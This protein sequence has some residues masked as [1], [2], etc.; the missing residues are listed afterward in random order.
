MH[1]CLL[2]PVWLGPVRA[3]NRVFSPPH[4]T[5]LG[6][7]GTVSEALIAYHRE[8]AKGGVGLI[9][10]E[11]MT[12]HPSYSFEESFLYAGSDQIIAGLEKLATACHPYGAPMFGQLF[13]AGR[14]VRLSRDGSRPVTYSAS[15]V[16][17][18]RYRVV[19]CPMP[20][21]MV[22]EVIESYAQAASR[23]IEGGLDGVEILASMGYLIAQF[24]NPNTNQ[25]EDEFGGDLAN[26]MRMLQEILVRCRERI[27]NDKTL[28][29]RITLNENTNS[30]MAREEMLEACRIIDQGSLVDYFSVIAGSSASMRGWVHVFPP[31]AVPHA[32][33]ADDA[34]ALKQV[35]RRPVLVAGRINQPQVAADIIKKG[36]AEMVGLGRALIADPEFV[37]KFASGKADNIRACVACNQACVG[38]RL[39]HHPIS[40][41]QHPESGRET[42]FPKT[43]TSTPPKKVLVIGGGPGG[44]KAAAL[45]ANSGQW[46]TLIEKENVLGGQVRLAERLPGRAEFGGVITN[47]IKE[48]ET[49]NVTILLNTPATEGLVQEHQPDLIV[50]ATGA[51]PRL[52]D[53][54]VGGMQHLNSWSACEEKERVGQQIVIADWA[55]D[56]AG[57]GLAHKYALAGHHVRLFSNG[58]APGESLQGIVRDQWIAEIH[59]IGVEITPYARFFGADNTTAWFQHTVSDEAIVC[60]N[61]DTLISCYASSS[62]RMPKWL[63][64]S[65]A[66][67]KIIGDALSPRTVEEAIL[68]AWVTVASINTS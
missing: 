11:G 66:P 58:T 37:N 28:G 60:E 34:L 32:F 31:M 16:P 51:K 10:L 19:P 29:V 23:L 54:P 8:R 43:G 7:N 14:A 5:T 13:H 6:K 38:H 67:L 68:E 35:V 3:Q 50:I 20:N 63:E 52:P 9:I 15:D 55:C 33:V 12:I 39:A 41:I 36:Y 24:L 53:S 22:W 64:A 21:E 40:C 45:A 27:G 25:R 44:M 61:V 46:V 62:I 49:G 65:N 47:L 2:E 4:G 17:D 1:D 59:R 57:L 30:G 26:R 42:L 56:W 18:E 48:L